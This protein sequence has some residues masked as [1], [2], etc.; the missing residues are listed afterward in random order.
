[1]QTFAHRYQLK[2]LPSAVGRQQLFA[3][4]FKL[5]RTDCNGG[6]SGITHMLCNQNC[7][8]TAERTGKG[9]QVDFESVPDSQANA[10]YPVSPPSFYI[11]TKGSSA[12]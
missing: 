8:F 3:G 1:M 9:F 12:L 6:L 7:I 5:D 10:L 4:W 11:S 2:R